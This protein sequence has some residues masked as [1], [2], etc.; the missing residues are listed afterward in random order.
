MAAYD[1]Q[2]ADDRQARQLLEKYLPSGISVL[3][4]HDDQF[5][6]SLAETIGYESD[7]AFSLAFKRRFGI[8]PGR[9]RTQ[10]QHLRPAA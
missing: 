10:M 3:R 2:V 7:T 1:L 5:E 8:S 6:A 9:Y 4:G